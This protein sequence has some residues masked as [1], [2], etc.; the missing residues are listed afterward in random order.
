MAAPVVALVPALHD[1]AAVDADWVSSLRVTLRPEFLADAG[2]DQ[3]NE[4]LAP[5]RR[6]SC[7]SASCST[8]RPASAAPERSC[9]SP[10]A[11]GSLSPACRWSTSPRL[12]PGNGT[13]AKTCV[14]CPA[15]SDHARA[16]P[17]VF[18]PLRPA[19]A[20]APAPHTGGIHR[21]TGGGRGPSPTINSP[22]RTLFKYRP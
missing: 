15:A 13:R 10:A 6:W 21:P 11:S 4:V 3:V 7:A 8:A 12:R 14:G 1:N 19:S 16:D 17:A 9:V 20:E 2:W 18:R 5:P 22:L